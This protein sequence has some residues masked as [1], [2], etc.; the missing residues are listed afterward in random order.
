[1]NR[2]NVTLTG[3]DNPYLQPHLPCRGEIE[4]FEIGM[5]SILIHTVFRRLLDDGLA[6]PVVIRDPSFEYSPQVD[7]DIFR[8]RRSTGRT[9]VQ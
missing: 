9:P 8:A 6:A 5:D 3:T 4:F 7:R 2:L 1:M